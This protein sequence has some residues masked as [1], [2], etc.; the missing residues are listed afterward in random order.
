MDQHFVEMLT[1]LSA[2]GAEYLVIGAHAVAAHGHLRGTR[3]IDIWVRPT[4]ENASRVW[5]SLVQFGAPLRGLGP[6]DFA[7]PETIY[8]IGVDPIR[9]DILTSPAG[10]D[11]D[12]AWPNRI[13]VG[14]KGTDQTFP[15]LG[16]D[17]LLRSKR[18]TG[19]LQDLADAEAIE[20]QTS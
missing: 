18:A 9:I 12:T 16:R 15:F 11:F 4:R 19:R 2:A 1:E 20:R 5:K 3:D 10:L 17:D 8:Q 6:E 13:Y 7:T 14:A